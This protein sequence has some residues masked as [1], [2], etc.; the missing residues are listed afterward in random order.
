VR[1]G[2][3]TGSLKQAPTAGSRSTPCATRGELVVNQTFATWLCKKTG[4]LYLV[5]RALGHRYITTTAIYARVCD[6]TL[7]QAV[8]QL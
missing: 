8:A 2:L 4:D 3:R 7:Q 1:C 5:Q 6:R